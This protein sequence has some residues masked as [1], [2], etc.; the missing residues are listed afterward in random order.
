MG[1]VL[2]IRHV[3]FLAEAKNIQIQVAVPRRLGFDRDNTVFADS[4]NVGI[5]LL[6]EFFGERVNAGVFAVQEENTVT[7][8]RTD[9]MIGG[10]QGQVFTEFVADDAGILVLTR[11][12]DKICKI[13][14]PAAEQVVVQFFQPIAAAEADA[15]VLLCEDQAGIAVHADAAG[16]GEAAAFVV[17]GDVSA[18]FQIFPAGVVHAVKRDLVIRDQ[19][20]YRQSKLLADKVVQGERPAGQRVGLTGDGADDTG[21]GNLGWANPGKRIL[22]GHCRVE[23]VVDLP[24]SLEIQHDFFRTGEKAVGG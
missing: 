5:M 1:I 3:V 19:T 10:G 4:G 21:G 7:V 13:R 18:P 14:D 16:G 11:T 17:P 15:H 9:D 12:D 2:G 20:E 8:S 6:V 24:L 22:R 23:G